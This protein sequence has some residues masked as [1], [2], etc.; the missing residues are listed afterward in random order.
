VDLSVVLPI[1]DERDNVEP[2]FDEIEAALLPTGRTFEIIAVDDGSR[3][4]TTQVLQRLAASRPHVKVL[5]FRRNHGQSAAFDAGFRHA[6]GDIVVTMDAD[7]Q[8]DPSDI[9]A[10]LAKL[11]EG[12]GY[13]VVTG[14]RLHRQDGFALRRLPS[15]LA[16]FLVRTITGTRVHDLGCSLRVYRRAITDELRLYGEMHRF[17]AV[18]A[19]DLGAR[20]GELVV[21]H[22]ARP[23]GKSKYGLSRTMRVL[24]DL[25]TVWFLKRYQT[26]P[27]YLFGGI[28]S[29]MALLGTILCAV[30][31]VEKFQL[32]VWVHRNP[33]FSIAVMCFLMAMQFIGAGLLA[34]MIVRTYF[35]SQGKPSY[36]IAARIGLEPPADPTPPRLPRTTD[37]IN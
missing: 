34:E 35:E 37:K 13:D 5:I 15:A 33:L 22:R 24:L 9:P 8:N 19:E 26:K 27:L 12:D 10:L 31:L 32:G 14:W 7:R 6:T 25:C 30:V 36:T 3:D 23:A 20:V 16:N 4:G 29:V 28:G 21:N 1:R 17:I 11:D 2:L 18:L